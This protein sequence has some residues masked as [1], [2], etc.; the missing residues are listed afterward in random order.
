[1]SSNRVHI[2]DT[3]LRDGEQSPGAR[4]TLG[5]KL[6]LA[7]QLDA[8]GVDV[9][10]A[11]FPIASPGERASVQAVA[12]AVKHATVAALCRTKEGDIE[13]AWDAI[14][15]AEKPRLHTFIATSDIHMEHK[16]RMTRNQVLAQIRRGVAACRARCSSVEF[17]AEDASRTDPVFLLEA[18]EAAIEAGATVLNVPDTVGYAVPAEFGALI[19]SVVELIGDRDVIVSA[20]CH[21]DLGLAVAN[22]LAAIEAGARQVECCVN[23][24]GERAGNAAL[25]EV[26]MAIRTRQDSIGC[27]TGIDATK[28]VATSRMVAEMTGMQ[29]AP[30][31]A[32]VGR[33]AFAHESGIH[34]HGVLAKRSTYEIMTPEHVGFTASRIVLGKLSG[35]HAL[36]QRLD[37]LGYEPSEPDMEQLFDR[38]KE[39]A[40][41]KR[42]VHDEDLH[43]LIGDTFDRGRPHYVIREVFVESGSDVLPRAKIDMQVGGPSKTAERDGD[44]PVDAV[45]QAIRACTGV[46]DATVSAYHVDAVTPGADAQGRVTLEVTRNG[47]S[48]RGH[49]THCDIVVASAQAYVDAL[50]RLR[51]MKHQESRKQTAAPEALA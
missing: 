48:A 34:Q 28:L 15:H 38:F 11:G 24:I 14:Q 44:G 19:A 9:I 49:G 6:Q 32:I 7:R 29:V 36:R 40:D 8:L 47:R 10:E 37:I 45:I 16:L 17:S 4:M 35:R 41:K 13:A 46:H 25:E 50:N 31:K 23:G 3:T 39:L 30:N 27:T 42:E 33:N 12:E 5:A 20:H 21:D 2:F 26:V 43:Q 18:F 51:A 1:M 22:S